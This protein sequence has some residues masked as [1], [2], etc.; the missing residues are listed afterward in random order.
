MPFV[1]PLQ[2]GLRANELK[3]KRRGR[4]EHGGGI[5]EQLNTKM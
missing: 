1:H 5:K 4:D 2:K 3:I